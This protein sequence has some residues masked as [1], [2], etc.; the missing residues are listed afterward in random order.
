MTTYRDLKVEKERLWEKKATV[1]PVAIGAL[2][3]ITEIS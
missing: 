1:V 2:G 3:A